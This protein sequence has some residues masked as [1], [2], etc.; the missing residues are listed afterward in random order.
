MFLTYLRMALRLFSRNKSFTLINLLG[1]T[2]GISSFLVI[3][4]FVYHELS[5]EEFW[6]EEQVYRVVQEFKNPEEGMAVTGAALAQAMSQDVSA[7]QNY[8]RLHRQN[9]F[10]TVELGGSEKVYEER[11][12]I[13]T[14]S[15][16]F[17]IFDLPL[18]Q[19]SMATALKNPNSVVLTETLA[20]K[21]FGKENPIHQTIELQGKLLY[22]QGV[23][24][25]LPP[26]THLEI[27]L[28]VSMD[29]FKE[30]YGV[31]GEFGS[32]WWPAVWTYVKLSPG[33][34]VQAINQQ[35]PEFIKKYR[36]AD[37]AANYIPQLQ[38]VGDIHLHSGYYSEIKANADIDMVYLFAFV[39]VLI[40]LIACIN[41]MN[42]SIVQASRRAK[43]IGI[44]KVNGA[45]RSSLVIRFM[46]E[47]VLY[48][49]FAI[50]LSVLLLQGLLPVFGDLIQRELSFNENNI[51]LYSILPLLLITALLAGYYPSLFVTRFSVDKALKMEASGLKGS[52]NWLYRGLVIFQ[53]TASV[54]LIAGTMITYGQ[55][56]YMKDASLGFDEEHILS[57]RIPNLSSGTIYEKKGDMLDNIENA[58]LRL[59]QVKMATTADYRPGFG[60]GGGALFEISGM[61]ASEGDQDRIN[62]MSVGYEYFALLNVDIVAGRDFDQRMGRETNSII[63][64][65][66]VL[67]K[68]NIPDPEGILGQEIRTYVREGDHIYG[69]RRGT[70]IGVV[71]DFHAA[72]LRRNIEPILFM[73]SE[74]IFKAGAGTLLVKTTE[75]TDM[76]EL[77]FS[78]KQ[79]WQK[80]YPQGT[81]EAKFLDESL[82]M[83]YQSE[84]RLGNMMLIFSILAVLIACLGLYGLAAYLM[85]RKIKEIGIR[86]VMGART[87]QL[88]LQFNKD[89]ALLLFISVLIAIPVSIYW[90]N[91]WLE[92]FAYRIE[93]GATWFLAAGGV[94]LI[95]ALL[96]VSYKAFQA[97]G[98]N[99][100]KALR[101]E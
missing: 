82:E 35:L 51:I 72:S 101:D 24:K 87:T 40:L 89:F 69:E 13:F 23:M 93:P 27:D 79:E 75:G 14:D 74:E 80:Y 28:L 49:A 76:Q 100:A 68:L 83:R 44:R 81:F 45:R 22:V 57:I 71:E 18:L 7:I 70:V 37:M 2:L 67:D 15:T 92:Q 41:Y 65:E 95:I 99:P 58:F 66:S 26:K 94:C 56:N 39:G 59:S 43:E 33:S 30:L 64:N 88:V 60:Q 50:G 6:E 16:F 42:L 62:R 12:L 90:S 25:D 31:R 63:V 29:T 3:L 97:A 77:L 52:N 38:A 73:P 11:N 17:E 53:F 1:L 10:I 20:R 48:A 36:E 55:L 9:S 46:S 47:S 21:Y 32:Y 91:H 96:T 86:K 5:Y 85:E 61:S 84:S 19:G 4:S 98:L 8:C 54:V 34:D 78:L